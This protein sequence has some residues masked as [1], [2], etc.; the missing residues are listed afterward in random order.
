LKLKGRS[1]SFE[2]ISGWHIKAA[3]I[4]RPRPLACFPFV[5]LSGSFILFQVNMRIFS[6]GIV[7]PPDLFA[8]P[9]MAE[10]DLPA[11]DLGPVKMT[12][13]QI[14][15]LLRAS[16][17][18]QITRED[19]FQISA[20]KKV[21]MY[22][23]ASG[24]KV[25]LIAQK[26]AS[27]PAGIDGVLFRNADGTLSW[28]VHRLVEAMEGE[29][30]VKGWPAVIAE[31]A[32]VWDG[33]FTY[34]AEAANP[35]GTVSPDNEGLRPPQLGALF[36]IGSHWSLYKSPATVVMP[37]G[38]GKTET[39]LATLAALVR[40]PCWSLFHQMRCVRRRRAKSSSPLAC[41]ASYLF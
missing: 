5:L 39:M 33:Q 28:V 17:K 32:K 8:S 4:L 36:A 12:V 14:H 24:E 41:C 38:T 1:P 35:D 31:R 25:I 3:P 21:L 16:E 22:H 37:T 18:V 23:L 11:V 26:K 10:L 2:R 9:G 29:A 7:A 30:K 27:R 6:G 13:G 34:K 20:R 15:C 19:T 40:D